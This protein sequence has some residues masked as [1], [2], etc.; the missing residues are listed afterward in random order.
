ML[1]LSP[2]IEY[3]KSKNKKVFCCQVTL[4]IIDKIRMYSISY[5]RTK[6]KE[7]D[8]FVYKAST[9]PTNMINGEL[10]FIVYCRLYMS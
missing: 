8:K 7:I 4:S 9:R 6:E 1:K 2:L 5:D 3:W 10:S